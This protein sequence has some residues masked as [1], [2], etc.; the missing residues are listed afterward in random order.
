MFP[1]RLRAAMFDA[2]VAPETRDGLVE[3]WAGYSSAF[4][5]AL[6]HLDQLCRRDPAC[7]LHEEGVVAA[8]DEVVALVGKQPVIS[9]D[10]VQLTDNKVRNIVG[11]LLYIEQAWP[12]IVS[13]LAN[14]QAGDYT[15]LFELLPV[16][17]GFNDALIPIICNTYGTRRAAADLLPFDA[18]FN[19]ANPRFFGRFTL[20]ETVALCAAWPKGEETII[21]NLQRDVARPILLIGNEFDNATPLSWT[22]SLAFA[23]GMERY[24]VRYQGGGHGVTTSG[25]P[26]S[27]DVIVAYLADL[28]LPAEG[29][30]CP[31]L[32]I[33]FAAPAQA[34]L[35]RDQLDLLERDLMPTR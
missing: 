12:L 13:A 15:L 8:F 6:Q 27:D 26:C 23:L 10:G 31:A 1:Q 7:R 17:E 2:G 32:P 28:R 20:S 24:L 19:A 3:F 5:F 11:E 16:A 33:S 4:E 9:P 30:T 18:A 25:N 14:A 22:R 21:R 35:T 34:S 29:F